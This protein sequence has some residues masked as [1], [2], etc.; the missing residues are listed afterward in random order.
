MLYAVK[1]RGEQVE[2]V[3]QIEVNQVKR[4]EIAEIVV[5]ADTIYEAIEK[6][7]S[8]KGIKLD[9]PRL[10]GVNDV[11]ETLEWSKQRVHMYMKRGILPEPI[12]QVGGR[13]AWTKQQIDRFKKMNEGK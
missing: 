7:A 13:P 6:A 8:E 5:E 9:P 12:T 11:A 3:E 2:K 10:Y 4:L 1:F